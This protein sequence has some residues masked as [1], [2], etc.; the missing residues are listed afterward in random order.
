LLFQV[1]NVSGPA[2]LGYSNFPPISGFRRIL[3]DGAKGLAHLQRKFQRQRNSMKT[4]PLLALVLSLA[5]LPFA[6]AAQESPRTISVSAEGEVSLP[7]D[8]ARLILGVTAEAKGSR[9]ALDQAGKVMRAIL[10]VVAG[11]GVDGKDVQTSAIRLNPRY[12]RNSQGQIDYRV[13]TG[14][15]AETTISLT[16]REL[17]AVGDLLAGAVEAGANRVD[18]ISF[19]LQSE[20][21]ALDEARRKAGLLAEAAGVA[22]G[23]LLQLTEMG[24][25]SYRMEIATMAM[26]ARADMAPVPVAPGEISFTASVSLVYQIAD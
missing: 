7:P 25:P 26:D 22:L 3:D 2:C 1:R 21:E 6:L 4:L 17:N 13:I 18:G 16:L 24:S 10:D 20:T 14:Y 19:G 12:G 23:P 5:F 9:E 15:T 8:M 11:Q